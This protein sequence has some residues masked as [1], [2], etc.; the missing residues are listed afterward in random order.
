MIKINIK[1]YNKSRS[2]SIFNLKLS[3]S[4]LS[5]LCGIS[6]II[7]FFQIVLDGRTVFTDE[8]RILTIGFVLY[9]CFFNGRTLFISQP[10]FSSIGP[11]VKNHDI[12]FIAGNEF[13]GKPSFFQG[14]P[15][16][17]SIG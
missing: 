11:V 5:E 13:Y 3:A 6:R 8:F 10:H 16:G 17:I 15:D 1:A 12:F 2:F 9:P 4:Q 7:V 14:N